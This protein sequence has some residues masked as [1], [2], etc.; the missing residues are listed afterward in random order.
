[1]LKIAWA[2]I[3][4]HSLPD[5]HR[6]PMRIYDLIPEQLIYEETIERANLFEPEPIPEEMILK[7]HERDYWDRLKNLDLSRKEERASGFPLS[8][9][10]VLRERTIM[11]GTVEAAN[12]ALEFGCAMNV[13][14]GTHHAYRDRAEGFCLLN[15]QAL[16]AQ[17]LIDN[18]GIGKIL[19]VDLD[20]HQGNGTAKIFENDDRVFTFSIHGKNNYPFHKED[21][22]L[23][24]ELNDGT[25][26]KEYLHILEE[27]LHEVIDSE[28]PEFMFYQCGVDILETDQLGK[29]A[30]T[31]QGCA[32]RDR[33]VLESAYHHGIPVVSSMGGGY[34]KDINI[35]VEAH[36]NTFRTAQEIFFEE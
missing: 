26:D 20:V 9:Q 23:D 28:K 15:D 33:I 14:G 18:K 8:Q 36:C 35:I 30:V 10:L 16:A 5:E 7:V 25:G 31:M 27:N 2:P 17:F 32:I 22:D 4:C 12:Y 29:M 21:S 3:Y 1:M 34:S 13:A 24:I 11:M 19:I 6:F